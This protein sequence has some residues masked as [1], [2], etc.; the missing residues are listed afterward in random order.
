MADFRRYARNF[1]AIKGRKNWRPFLADIERSINARP[2]Q[3]LLGLAPLEVDSWNS[4]PIQ[5]AR[6]EL[7]D[8]RP[9]ETLGIKVGDRVKVQL[10][11]SPYERGFQDAPKYSEE[12]FIVDSWLTNAK[13][14]LLKLVDLTGC[15]LNQYYYA[16]QVAKV[17]S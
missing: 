16:R 14:Y 2:R 7:A 8:S 13:P 5:Q 3:S 6:Q 15:P 11:K 4:Q 9:P 1:Q 12:E 10:P 17:S